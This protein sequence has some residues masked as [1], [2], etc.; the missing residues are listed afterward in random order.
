MP[1]QQC[2]RGDD[3]HRLEGTRETIDVPAKY[4]YLSCALGYRQRGDK[5]RRDSNAE[6][7]SP[8]AP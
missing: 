5:G 3:S 8:E 6:G 7:D 2:N 4:N 1:S